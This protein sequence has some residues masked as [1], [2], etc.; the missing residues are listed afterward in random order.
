MLRNAYGKAL[1]TLLFLMVLSFSSRAEALSPQAAPSPQPPTGFVQAKPGEIFHCDRDYVWK[2]K[3]QSCDSA[4]RQDGEKLRPILDDTPDAVSELD[5]YQKN[6][7]KVRAAAYFGTLGIVMILAGVLVSRQYLDDSG[8]LTP[9][10]TAIL[11]IGAYGGVATA[12]VS[13]VYG[14]SMLRTNEAHLG[15][16]VQFY[17]S[18]HPSTPIELQFSTGF[19]F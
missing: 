7:R 3:A 10:G 8:N 2:G 16:A 5:T 1:F 6:R 9:T 14:L 4:A 17:N 13:L 19:N 15:R 12:G 11:D 18:K